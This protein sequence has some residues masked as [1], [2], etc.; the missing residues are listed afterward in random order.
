MGNFFLTLFGGGL[1]TLLDIGLV[2]WITGLFTKN[3]KTKR[4]VTVIFTICLII[5]QLGM[6]E[7]N[8]VAV[9]INTILLIIGAIFVFGSSGNGNDSNGN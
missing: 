9:I 3:K 4:I 6:D 1:A 5:T 7:L 8:K 2:Y